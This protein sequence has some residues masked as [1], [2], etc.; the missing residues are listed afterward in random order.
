M[1]RI[2]V[3][4]L[5]LMA[6]S[7]VWGQYL[8]NF[9]GTGETKTAYASGNVTL[10]GISWNL[11]DALIGTDAA[12]WKN[13]VRSTRMRGYGTSVISMLA[14]KANGLGTLSFYYR[15]YGTDAQ[16]DWKA[17][18]S[19]NDGS[20]WTQV[21][22]SFT[23][24]ASD[25]VQQFSVAVNVSGNV[26]VRIKRA[27]ETGT[28]S[29]R[30]NIDDIT[31][32]DYAGLT[33]PSVTTATVTDVTAT[34]ATSGGN[35]TSDG[36]A[37]VTARGVCW[38]ISANPTISNYLSNDGSGTGSFVSSLS[39]LTASTLYYYRAYA[40]NSQGTAYGEEYS[41]STSG[42]SPPA[43]P[44]A[45]AATNIGVNSFTANWNA[46]SGATSYRLDVS[47]SN[48]FGTMLSGYNNL[49][50]SS[51]SQAVSGLNASTSYYYRVR[52]Y[53]ANGT[54]SNSGTI[55]ATTLAND[56]YD[57]YYNSVSG[58]T[59]NALK[60][61]LHT[62]LHSTHTTQF[63]YTNLET[64]MKITDE[65][66]NNTNNVIEIYTG[67]S[68]PKSSYGGGVTDWNKEH[69]WSKSHGDFGNTAPAG[70]DLHHLRP[71]DATVNSF[72]S[73]RDFD[74]G[75]TSYTD[76]S[77]PAGYTGATD[78]KYR[79]SDDFEPRDADKGDVARMIFYMAVRY[80]G[81]DTSYDLELVDYI[82]SDAGT[83]QPFYG[84]LS[85]L[86]A[87]HA[88]DPPDAWEAL[89]NNRIKNL[90][91]NRNPF[92]DHPE[93]VSS[94]WGGAVPAT[95]VQFNPTSAQVNEADGSVILT[96][97]IANPSATTAT[98]AQITLTSGSA[99]DV[100]NYS[101]RTL[102]FPA[103]SSANQTTSVSITNDSLL[104]GT[105][106]LV[107][108]LA[109]VSGGSSAVI[110]TNGSFT[111]EIV[112]NDIPTPVATAATSISYTGFTANWNAASGITDYQF[113]LSTASDFS[114]FVGAYQNY[115][116][117]ATNLDISGLTQ[118]TNYYY[119]VKAIY[120]ASAGSYSSPIT[121]TTSAIVVLDPPVA[122]DATA[123]SHEGF[124]AR[125]EAVSGADNY[126]LDVFAG[127]GGNTTSIIIS[128]Y[129]EG[130]SNN[131][132]VE[133]Y[134]GTGMDVDLTN[135]KLLLFANGAKSPNNTHSL[136][137]IMPNNSCLVFK[138]SS[139][140]LTLPE[141]VTAT[142]STATNFN[143]NDV[144]ALVQ[145]IGT[146]TTYYD[147]FGNIGDATYWSSGSISATNQT[148][149]RKS[150]VLS[151]VTMDISGTGFPTLATEWDTF[152]IDT[153]SDL[154]THS[155]GGASTPV[156]GY[157]DLLVTGNVARISGL[158][159]ETTYSY[160]V[161]AENSSFTTG[162]SN[163]IEA[164]TTASVQGT[165]ANTCIS[166]AETTVLIPVLS[167]Y[168]NN[169]VVINPVVSS[170]DDFAVTVSAITGGIRYSFTSSNS[171]AYNAAYT[172]NHAGL[173]YSPATVLYRFN[174][175]E[176]DASTFTTSETQTSLSISGLSGSGNLEIDL[177]QAPPTLDI[178]NVTISIIDGNVT[179]SWD[180]IPNATSYLIEASDTPQGSFV[181][182]D[183]TSLFTWSESPSTTRFYQVRA[184]RD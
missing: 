61:G 70:T 108:S 166:G 158:E 52:A 138:N 134:N 41:F 136:S 135:Y 126:R 62:I 180:E 131:K 32:T 47:T 27:T 161:R 79:T 175:V 117:S 19:L 74:N 22:S 121:V 81:V 10:S 155:I 30:L 38:N 140:V 125:W 109:N 111:L 89:R 36:G 15:R 7:L 170:S 8:V 129:V 177:L 82:Y 67:W 100:G 163:T 14:N 119:R 96:V 55:T 103:N 173:G 5:V 174:S 137:G 6:F 122:G 133:L 110:G 87:W 128:E 167:V 4:T 73:N 13:G 104:E 54:S 146:D 83:N 113:D 66:P 9:E 164:V 157:Q 65:D 50:V 130:N 35:V 86:L 43:I 99:A 71:C 56:P 148:L 26:R 44:T 179:L 169:S 114:S 40:T 31:L 59:G 101:T 162:N 118:G 165:G 97:E 116:V 153:V 142:N 156:A 28:S 95:T 17:E 75:T 80:D 34:S 23:S 46:A 85:T 57:G 11:T 29:N 141:G 49:T 20:S 33:T 68:V 139:A 145:V 94:I 69:T 3:F 176:T 58:L 152:A 60:N 127:S 76:A 124:T 12:D 37:S 123:I 51:T 144:V 151:G 48:S 90:Q 72:K 42:N 77:P 16:V 147:I 149:R 106:T 102:T 2:I 45:T 132:Y 154:G 178:P 98:T 93:Y 112:D 92:I 168:T 171:S 120:N 172:L 105:E 88:S 24:P 184:Y 25:V 182:I 84:K 78:C 143:G 183:S 160:R 64:Q 181:Q 150:E 159:P 63:S 18:Y 39:S 107:F 1:K 53:N 21:G 91:G 115:T